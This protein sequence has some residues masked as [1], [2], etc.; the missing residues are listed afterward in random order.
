MNGFV[1]ALLVIGI[2]IMIVVVAATA[3]IF[4]STVALAVQGTAECH[5]KSCQALPDNSKGCEN[6]AEGKNPHCG[7][8]D[9]PVTEPTTKNT[10]KPPAPTQHEPANTPF[11]PPKKG[12]QTVAE[13][14]STV[15]PGATLQIVGTPALSC[16]GNPCPL[17]GILNY[18]ATIAQAAA[19]D[20]NRKAT[21]WAFDHRP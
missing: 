11:Q 8:K 12:G 3:D 2:V 13:V 9:Q 10:D 20:E 5:G 1:K 19:N 17:E 7:Q 6:S 14:Q 21:N 4:R 18:V 15:T 16:G